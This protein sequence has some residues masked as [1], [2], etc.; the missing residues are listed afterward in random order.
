MIFSVKHMVRAAIAASVIAAGSAHA[1]IAVPSSGNGSLLLYVSNSATQQVYV[2]DLGLHVD[3]IITQGTGAG[4]TGDASFGASGTYN[5]LNF[6]LGSIGPDSLLSSFLTG[7]L[8]TFSWGVVAGDTVGGNNNSGPRRIVSTAGSNASTWSDTPLSNVYIQNAGSA[9][10][11]FTVKV[12]GIVG[13]GTSA[14]VSAGAGAGQIDQV[15]LDAFFGFGQSVEG[16]V[17]VGSAQDF[18][19]FSSVA[20]GNPTLSNAFVLNDLTLSATGA[21]ASVAASE[22]PLPAA[23]WLFGSGLMGLAGIGRRRKKTA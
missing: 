10:N 7:D 12:A 14:L 20:G 17:G 13:S 15:A 3:D 16:A 8:S 19:L 23:A 6:S 18:Y 22:V 9:A 1:A 11:A 21:L 5:T 4:Q 2:R